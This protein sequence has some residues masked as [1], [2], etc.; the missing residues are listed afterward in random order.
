MQ[1]NITRHILFPEHFYE[2]SVEEGLKSH[3]NEISLEEENSVFSNRITLFRVEGYYDKAVDLVNTLY[4]KLNLVVTIG[5]HSVIYEPDFSQLKKIFLEHIYCG[6]SEIVPQHILPKELFVTSELPP[7]LDPTAALLDIMYTEKKQLTNS[8]CNSGRKEIRSSSILGFLRDKF[9]S[10]HEDI[11]LGIKSTMAFLV[12]RVVSDDFRC[13]TLSNINLRTVEEINLTYFEQEYTKVV[14]YVLFSNLHI[15]IEP[16]S[17]GVR[18][19]IPEKFCTFKYDNIITADHKIR[20]VIE[21]AVSH[22]KITL[23]SVP[24]LALVA[25]HGKIL[26]SDFLI[27]FFD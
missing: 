14:F 25:S 22:S 7:L 6:S 9:V 10:P 4:S 27:E 3:K 8:L 2:I 20:D 19:F 16:T 11:L 18:V 26:N 24:T 23:N 5:F 17:S 21:H 13:R 1:T 12:I 15:I